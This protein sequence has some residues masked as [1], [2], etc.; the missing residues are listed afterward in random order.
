[1]DGDALTVTWSATRGSFAAPG[2]FMTHYVCP[3]VSLGVVETETLTLSVDDRHGCV[4]SVTMSVT[5]VGPFGGTCVTSLPAGTV[6]AG[7][8]PGTADSCP[9]TDF[10]P[11]D[12]AALR[13]YQIAA[14]IEHDRLQRNIGQYACG[15]SPLY[16]GTFSAQDNESVLGRGDFDGAI[17]SGPV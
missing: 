4:A 17:N 16:R 6:T 8:A 14:P 13:V 5:C 1:A 9:P 2:S 15:T 12:A 10:P 11:T 7:P 3:A